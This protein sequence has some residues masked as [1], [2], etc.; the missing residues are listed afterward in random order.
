MSTPLIKRRRLDDPSSAL[1]KPFKSPLKHD[2]DPALTHPQTSHPG[3]TTTTT[4]TTT[5]APPQT[6]TSKPASDTPASPNTVPTTLP[7]ST[8][9]SHSLRRTNLAL[10]SACRALR[11]D[12]DTLTSAAKILH[13]GRDAELEKL[14]ACWKRVSR[15]AAEEVF[16][17]VRDKVNRMGG[18]GAWREREREKREWLGG[19]DREEGKG[20]GEDGEDG[21]G[22]EE[23]ERREQYEGEVSEYD[24]REEGGRKTDPLFEEGRDDDVS[25]VMGWEV[26][27]GRSGEADS[28]RQ[29]FT[30]DMMLRQLNVE[31]DVIGYDREEQRWVD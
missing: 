16:A 2:A 26:A 28:S 8:E 21:E 9:E 25:E 23:R 12:I 29:T 19:W 15:A 24:A 27:L 13:S 22:G 17:G 4:T 18:V 3:A 7:P 10:D 11:E 1:H 20:G 31:L 5:S 30:M 14:I 6:P